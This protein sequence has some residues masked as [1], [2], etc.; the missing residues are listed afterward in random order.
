MIRRDCSVQ[1]P[2]SFEDGEAALPRVFGRLVYRGSGDRRRRA[3]P[4]FA[5]AHE[6]VPPWEGGCVTH[7][8][9]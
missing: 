6:E 8:R 2:W 3:L 9:A 4:A 5:E 1:C 7:N